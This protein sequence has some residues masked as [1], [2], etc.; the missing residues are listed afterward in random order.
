MTFSTN[1]TDPNCLITVL[2]QGS[3]RILFC[4]VGDHCWT[5]LV[6]PHL[7]LDDA[8]YRNGSFYLLNNVA[9]YIYD[10]NQQK[11]QG[12]YFFKPELQ[13]LSKF[14]L[15]GKSELYMVVVHRTED[16]GVQEALTKAPKQK[17]DLYRVQEQ[18][19]MEVE[20]IADTSDITIFNGDHEHYLAVCADDWDSLDEG[21]MYK[22]YVC[23]SSV[24]N[25]WDELCHSIYFAKPIDGNP[26]PVMWFQPSFV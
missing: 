21:C 20:R 5:Q 12:T 10:L 26:E 17:I 1:L 2:F 14:F 7:V 3:Q 22:E 19:W 24:H 15:V 4:K 23:S 11:A 18:Q 25:Y 6:G 16:R 8:A 13:S 9:L